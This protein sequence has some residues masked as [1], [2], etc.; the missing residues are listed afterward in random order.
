MPA[1]VPSYMTEFRT[2]VNT[3]SKN[4]I[5][6]AAFPALPKTR[7]EELLQ[8]FESRMVGTTASANPYS[9]KNLQQDQRLQALNIS[10][11]FQWLELKR[12]KLEEL[13]AEIKQ[14]RRTHHQHES[15]LFSLAPELEAV[16]SDPQLLRLLKDQDLTFLAKLELAL[17]TAQTH[18]PVLNRFITHWEDRINELEEQDLILK[19][20]HT[21]AQVASLAHTLQLKP[22]QI[23]RPL[24]TEL[25]NVVDLR[26]NGPDV[27][28]ILQIVLPTPKPGARALSDEETKEQAETQADFVKHIQKNHEPQT[29]IQLTGLLRNIFQLPV[30]QTI[31]AAEQFKML[32]VDQ[33]E[34]LT[35]HARLLEEARGELISL[36]T[37]KEHLLSSMN[38]IRDYISSNTLTLPEVDRALARIAEFTLPSVP[39]TVATTKPTLIATSANNV[40][41]TPTRTIATPT[42]PPPSDPGSLASRPESTAPSP[43]SMTLKPPGF[44][45]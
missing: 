19:R 15:I 38:S 16:E 42:P 21:D 30:M 26:A 14:Y 45:R 41:A 44:R 35:E 3:L 25:S 39:Q 23:D 8:D 31:R 43:F 2:W 17:K 11:F 7:Q 20:S 18:I 40:T 6:I 36:T 32:R 4:N 29:I 13:I 27:A 28:R 9:L 22:N 12:I 1:L 34:E 37:V 24:L 33:L 5:S 10:L